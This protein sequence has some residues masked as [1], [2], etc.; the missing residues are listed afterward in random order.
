MAN[1]TKIG[2]AKNFNLPSQSSL[3]PGNLSVNELDLVARAGSGFIALFAASDGSYA[4]GTSPDLSNDLFGAIYNNALV[5][6]P[7]KLLYEGNPP[8]A[9]LTS[10]YQIT[11][12][13]V[14]VLSDGRVF[15]TFDSGQDGT[16][17]NAT[18]TQRGIFNTTTNS[19]RS[20]A[21]FPNFADQFVRSIEA[22]DR[23]GMVF[24]VGV[25]AQFF[26]PTTVV[27]AN[28]NG[29]VR[30]SVDFTGDIA[31]LDN[32]RVAAADYITYANPNE[33]SLSASI[34]SS[35]GVLQTATPFLIEQSQIFTTANQKDVYDLQLSQLKS[36][37]QGHFAAT[38]TGFYYSTPS[39]PN[40]E[41]TVRLMD[42]N[43]GMLS[44]LIVVSEGDGGN[45]GKIQLEGF[46]AL[47]N[48]GFLIGYEKVQG[49]NYHYYVRAYDALGNAYGPELKL[50]AAAY[51]GGGGSSTK[52]IK[53]VLTED[54][55]IFVAYND[56][57]GTS[58]TNHIE[59]QQLGI[60]ENAAPTY[61]TDGG[62]T[63]AGTTGSD[64]YFA[65][66]G[67]DTVNG[68][69][70][71]DNIFG[72][73]G[74]DILNG[75]NAG[76]H[77]MGGLGRDTM[78]GGNGAGIGEDG[79]RDY[80]V[81]FDLTET[82]KTVATRDT[83]TDF[84]KGIASVR[85]AIDLSAIDANNTLAGNQAFIFEADGTFDAGQRGQ[86]IAVQQGAD[87]LIR[88]DFDGII[89]TIEAEIL[90]K[91]VSSIAASDFIL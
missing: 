33:S 38:W 81:Y 60:V 69:A 3:A 19:L 67:N 73:T 79:A 52:G 16:S 72:Q 53:F 34:Y 54:G 8:T 11:K 40:T 31:A 17:V 61:G 49:G 56:A 57:A 63:F 30:N 82:G 55:K 6:K 66:A 77:I 23:G 47:P 41:F 70:G 68:G 89:S 48:G 50:D 78:S 26:F 22:L 80:F 10:S 27:F 65:E 91:G 62:N 87:Y 14:S 83:I 59:L 76:D 12:P 5:A 85:D 45:G 15:V 35:N 64:V 24:E 51:S 37:G 4:A 88:I 84:G 58:T 75:G 39:Q 2:T 71:A 21:D 1:L 18:G 20:V 29:S 36:G 43:G 7:Y 32:Y 86:I 25:G 28:A 42:D 9:P 74:N 90:V 46:L 44:K 13:H